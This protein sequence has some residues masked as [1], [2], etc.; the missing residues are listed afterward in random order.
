LGGKQ[1][2]LQWVASIPPEVNTHLKLQTI[3]SYDNYYGESPHR[4]VAFASLQDDEAFVTDAAVRSVDE[5]LAEE[6]GRFQGHV[7]QLRFDY[8]KSF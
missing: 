6:V 8:I 3:A 1:A 2:Y 5:A 7:F 4:L